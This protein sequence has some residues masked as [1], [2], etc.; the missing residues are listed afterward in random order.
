MRGGKN[1]QPPGYTIVEVLIVLAVSGMM[2]LIATL[3]I[4]GKQAVTQFSA[5][6][7]EFA[8]DMQAVSGQVTDG[9]Y[10][11]IPFTCTPGASSLAFA[12]QAS[13]TQGT[14][15]N[16]IFLGK[17]VH[18][19]GVTSGNYQILPLAGSRLDKNG[20]GEPATDFT[21]ARTSVIYDLS[22]SVDLTKQKVIPQG[23]T[24]KSVT[25]TDSGLISHTDYSFGFSQGLGASEGSGSGTYRSGSQA[26]QLIWADQ[27]ALGSPKTSVDNSIG[28]MG[29]AIKARICVTDGS[30]VASVTIDTSESQLNVRTRI[31]DPSC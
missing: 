5:G 25:V 21:G 24:I 19:D 11:D 30:R 22:G 10:S 7:R 20:S 6:T 23:L 15:S 12:V 18:F 31:G 27:S 2:F 17:L 16:C 3:F 1:K 26:P 28:K 4:S 29:I 8:T 14:N 13:A 9:Q